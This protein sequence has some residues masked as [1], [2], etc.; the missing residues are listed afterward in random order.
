MKHFEIHTIT[1]NL[2]LLDT[3]GAIPGYQQFICSYLYTGE[4]NALIDI[5]PKACL[6]NVINALEELKIDPGQIDYIILSHIHLDHA[7]GVGAA[8]NIMTKAMVIAHSRARPHLV[9]PTKLWKASLNTL[10]DVARSYGEI[11]PVAEGRIIDAEEGMKIY[12]NAGNEPEIYMTPGHAAHSI[13][14]F[15]PFDKVLLA[16]EAAGDCLKGM[17]RP[18]TPPPFKLEAILSSIDKLVRLKP[19]L[20]CYAHYGCYHDAVK[21]LEHYR[22]KIMLW[23]EIITDAAKEEKDPEALF[24]LM[25]EKD[26]DLGYLDTLDADEYRREH[27]LILNSILGISNSNPLYG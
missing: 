1:P 3:G 16:G 21:R 4:K 9:D 5:G 7:G 2:K 14:M 11:E 26:A 20:I 19:E 25:R 6:P 24:L 13:S 8:L 10:G 15:N 12:L 17:T 22:Q 23:N 18:A 27:V